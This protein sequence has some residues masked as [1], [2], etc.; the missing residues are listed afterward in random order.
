MWVCAQEWSP[1]LINPHLCY[2]KIA[3]NI[4]CNDWICSL[5]WGVCPVVP[6]ICRRDLSIGY[7]TYSSCNIWWFVKKFASV[8]SEREKKYSCVL[9]HHLC[10]VQY[11]VM[12]ACM[13]RLSYFRIKNQ[14]HSGHLLG[15]ICTIVYLTVVWILL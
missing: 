15:K 2:V 10:C 7:W 14:S 8:L 12:F 4:C 5:C 3:T 13:V 6:L 9:Y 1:V 11:Y